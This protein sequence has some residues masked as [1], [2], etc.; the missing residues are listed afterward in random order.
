M[1]KKQKQSKRQRARKQQ[2]T[3]K[4]QISSKLSKLANQ[5]LEHFEHVDLL[6]KVG[7][8]SDTSK[9]V[10][11]LDSIFKVSEEVPKDTFNSKI[12]DVLLKLKTLKRLIALNISNT[13][14][15]KNFNN[16]EYIQDRK[17]V[18]DLEFKIQSSS[19]VET[20]NLKI[21][22]QL[23]KKHKRIKQLFD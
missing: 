9:L 11:S 23:Y 12:E 18:I 5:H 14:G 10:N 17:S 7:E 16:D 4:K 19:N 3:L 22:N 15:K 2:P 1:A 6:R 8:K 13:E 20:E 21:M